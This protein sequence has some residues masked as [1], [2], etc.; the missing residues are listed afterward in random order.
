MCAWWKRRASR[1]L[2]WW[3]ATLKT[4]LTARLFE[5]PGHGLARQVWI[6]HAS[7]DAKSIAVLEA[8]GA[9]LIAMPGTQGKVDLAGMLHDLGRPRGE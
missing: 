9:T 2:S 8:R 1:T 6:Y 7:H 3:T 5:P 4:P